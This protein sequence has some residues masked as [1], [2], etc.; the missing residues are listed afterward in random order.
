MKIFQSILMLLLFLVLNF[1]R[2]SAQKNSTPKVM[3]SMDHTHLI[4]QM[5]NPIRIVAQ[6]EKPVSLDQLSAKL[7]IYDSEFRSLEI[8]EGKGY[9]IIRPDTIGMVELKIDMGD[10]I[11]IKRLS[12]RS[13]EAV[14]RLGRYKSNTDKPISVGEFKVQIGIIANIECCDIDARCRILGY[15]AMRL[16][17]RNEVERTVNQGAK[18]TKQTQQ[19]ISKVESGDVFIFRK[20]KYRCPGSEKLQRLDDM[21]FEIE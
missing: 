16:S 18:F 15:E 4:A 1:T 11:E 21:I 10:T 8:I 19:M 6:Q 17:Q 3:T 5:N 20:I 13:I 12:V 2:S 7:H 9:F 14:G